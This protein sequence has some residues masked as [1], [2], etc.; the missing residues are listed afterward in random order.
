[1]RV[2][3]LGPSIRLTVEPGPGPRAKLGGGHLLRRNSPKRACPPGLPR[4]ARGAV[5]KKKTR[6][7]CS[8]CG[9]QKKLGILGGKPARGHSY[10]GVAPHFALGPGAG[11]TVRIGLSARHESRHAA[12]AKKTFQSLRC[13]P[14]CT[15][16]FRRERQLQ[17]LSMTKWRMRSK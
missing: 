14:Y 11:A 15:G 2:R 7:T 13:F 12:A 1:V 6:A 17:Q 9:T 4:I 3:V 16:C 5:L 8:G 10:V